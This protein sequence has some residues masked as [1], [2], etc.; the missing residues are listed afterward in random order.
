MSKYNPLWDYLKTCE[1]DSVILSFHEIQ[2]IAGYPV[3]HSFLSYKKE[4]LEYGYQVGKISIKN[5]TI[6]FNKIN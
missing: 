5:K 1:K 3:D 4:L 2:Q 6:S